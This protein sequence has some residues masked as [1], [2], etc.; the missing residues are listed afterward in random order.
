MADKIRVYQAAK[1]WELSTKDL[2]KALE[3]LGIK[4]KFNTSVPMEE[5][6]KARKLA[7][8]TVS[9]APE[10]ETASKAP[11]KELEEKQAEQPE[12]PAAEEKPAAKSR[13]QKPKQEESAA[14]GKAEKAATADK[15]AAKRPSAAP[16]GEAAKP[17]KHSAKPAAPSKGAR[18]TT[19][20]STTRST[21]RSTTQRRTTQ[22][23]PGRRTG[24]RRKYKKPAAPQPVLETPELVEIPQEITVKEFADLL[25]KPGSELVLKLMELGNPLPIT[26]S[27]DASLAEELGR[28]FDVEVIVKTHEDEQRIQISEVQEES[29]PV[30][31]SKLVPR[32]PVVTVMGH[33]D[34]GKTTLLDYIRNTSVAEGEAGG[35][36]QSIGASEVEID[37]KRIV[38]IDTPGHEAFTQMRARGA[39]V[40]DLVILV[41]AADDG[42]KPQTIEAIDHSKAAK[43]PLLVAINKID[44]PGAN[45]DR[46]KAELAEHGLTPEDWGG[47]TVM[48]EVSAKTGENVDE[49]L[50]ALLLMAEME[51]LKAD[52][53]GPLHGVVIEAGLDSSQGAL[54][55]VIIK[56]GTLKVGDI[57]VAGTAWGRVRSMVSASGAKVKQAGPS[58]A[59][60]ISGLNEVP[61]AGEKVQVV[62]KPK[63]ARMLVE[64]RLQKEKQS[65]A[66]RHV[67]LEEL[68]Q[69]VDEGDLKNL[70]MVIKARDQ[71]MLD[72]L[73]KALDGLPKGEV[74]L[75]VLHAGVGN[76]SDNDVHLAAASN[77]VILG[78]GVRVDSAAQRLAETEKIQIR[79]YDIIYHL[80]DDL[81]LAMEG[82]L[83]PEVNEVAL[84]KAEVRQ[85]FSFSRV[86]TIAGC[87][88]L[89]GVLRRNAK[90]RVKRGDDVV[91]EGELSSLR[92]HD[93]DR[94]EIRE[95]FECGLTLRGFDDFEPG[96][97]IECY[98]LEESARKLV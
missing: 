94:T 27:M 56:Q 19:S 71:G 49:L 79:T 17:S 61:A 47:D 89:E 20:T 65:R 51:E 95:G 77:A 85:L 8:Q 59:V 90:V 93:E 76:I 6:E 4:A 97:I 3:S 66:S 69:L 40:T 96:D 58:S 26:A 44:T 32:A 22:R 54:A 86:G 35:I 64:E 9:A 91:F 42:V 57:V 36:T 23:R 92:H 5:L 78:F 87:Y 13:K 55:T 75:E 73:K 45:P 67:T 48:V 84:G 2:L 1:K 21:R 12:A 98:Q 29:K 25:H 72:A 80:L 52:P 14:T 83:S 10:P 7:E 53:T 50:E 28:A 70:P 41:V 34:H 37:G 24:S 39:M 74:R 16:K 60:Q 82:M 68:K 81:R 31:D 30:D 11:A 63:E 18:G 33:V 62:A 88:V 46:V 15:S 38:F 43:V